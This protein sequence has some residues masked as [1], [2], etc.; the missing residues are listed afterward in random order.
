[1]PQAQQWTIERIIAASRQWVDEVVIKENFCP[2]AKREQDQGRIRYCV[3]TGNGLEQAVQFFADELLRLDEEAQIETTLAIYPTGFE[4]FDDYLE[5]LELAQ[6]VLESIGYE[7]RYQIASFHPDYC[8]E[9]AEED[10][11]ANYTNRSPFPM[12]HLL[13]EAGLNQALANYPDPESIPAR[14]VAHAQALG[15]EEL[16]GRID[17]ILLQKD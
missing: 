14:N 2:F 9:G 5:L 11:A 1:M 10:D 3:A 7:G 16:Q 8:F 13:R 6:Q 12:L 15:R 4:D 17:A